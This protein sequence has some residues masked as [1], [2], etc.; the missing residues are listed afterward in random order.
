MLILRQFPDVWPCTTANAAF[1]AR[2]YERWGR[3]HAIVRGRARRA[4]YPPFTQSLSIKAAWGGAETYLVDS[5]PVRVDDDGWLVL[6]EGRT[7]GSTICEPRP[8]DSFAVFFAPGFAGNVALAARASLRQSL[9][10]HGERSNAPIG[11]AEHLHAHDTSVTPLLLDLLESV[12][13]G[14]QDAEWFEEQL[15]LLVEA[16]LAADCQY[17][18]LAE[19]IAAARP[20]TR[21]ELL[22]RISLAADAI[23]TRFAEPLTLDNIA[24]AAGLSKFHLVRLYRAVH[25]ITP[26]EALQRKRARAAMRLLRDTDADMTDVAISVGFGTRFTLFRQLRRHYGASGSALRSLHV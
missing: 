26:Y 9:D 20:A 10:E 1:R 13:T 5:R 2:F 17:A 16:M 15:Q 4:E 25:G 22:R 14:E 24:A 6:N 18:R 11:F 12:D 8:T 3:E 7:Y 19:R 23:Q 21:V